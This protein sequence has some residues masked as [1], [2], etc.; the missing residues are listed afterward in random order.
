MTAPQQPRHDELTESPQ[1]WADLSP[2]VGQTLNNR[3]VIQHSQEGD[4]IRRTDIRRKPGDDHAYVLHRP[5]NGAPAR[6][7]IWGDVF[8]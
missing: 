6:D 2:G 1:D 4:P 8:W 7:R 5:I 3:G